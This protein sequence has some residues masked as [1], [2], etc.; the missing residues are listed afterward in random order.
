MY[1]MVF[2]WSPLQSAVNDGGLRNLDNNEEKTGDGRRW[3]ATPFPCPR[4]ISG[5]GEGMETRP[6]EGRSTGRIYHYSV[7]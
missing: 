3:K 4:K 5:L 6:E 7:L 2:C 1:L